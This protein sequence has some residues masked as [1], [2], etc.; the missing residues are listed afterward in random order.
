MWVTNGHAMVV[1]PEGTKIPEY[2]RPAE[3]PLAAW[4]VS[5]AR[6]VPPETIAVPRIFIAAGCYGD[7][8]SAYVA[9]MNDA[10][11]A[12]VYVALAE[13]LH[14]G[15]VWHVPPGDKARGERASAYAVANGQTVMVLAAGA[16]TVEQARGISEAKP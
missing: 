1:R 5:T 11:Y 9:E 14:P 7:A 13:T 3:G 4:M 16:K 2:V 15:C 8:A 6:M 10:C 12:L